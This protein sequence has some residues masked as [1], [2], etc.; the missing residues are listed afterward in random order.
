[1]SHEQ[2][3]AAS[4]LSTNL[5]QDPEGNLAKFFIA[6]ETAASKKCIKIFG[7]RGL[8]NVGIGIHTAKWNRQHPGQARPAA[9]VRPQLPPDAN[10]AQREQHKRDMDEWYIYVE[11]T[12]ILLESIIASL[13]KALFDATWDVDNGHTERS[14]TWFLDYLHQRFGV[15][16]EA[17]LNKLKAD[18]ASPFSSED[19]LE[20]LCEL[21]KGYFAQL[22]LHGQPRSESDKLLNF[23]AATEHLLNV[24]YFYKKYCEDIE[25]NVG[26]RTLNAAITYILSQKSNFKST[27]GSVGWAGA[28]DSTA[29]A[30]E[31]RVAEGVKLAL[32]QRAAKGDTAKK[33]TKKWCFAHGPCSH[34]GDDCKFMLAY[35]AFFTKEFRAAT[36]TCT[37]KGIESFPTRVETPP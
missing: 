24:P 9:M 19:D 1:M 18:I 3:V 13:N 17:A 22:A 12:T 10:V 2:S 34:R 36:K 21:L 16:T 14:I 7:P 4:A 35:P 26:N 31:R 32:A 11:D 23:V 28:V 37:I 27:S 15:V 29:A 30:F 33:P 20:S 5:H 8:L 6:V 25:R